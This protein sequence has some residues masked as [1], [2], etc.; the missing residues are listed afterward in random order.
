M[1]AAST[2]CVVA[3]SSFAIDIREITL[4]EIYPLVAAGSIPAPRPGVLN[5]AGNA[6]E[7]VADDM[8]N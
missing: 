8:A 6:S 3:L 7:W 1:T 5:L 4:G 2:P